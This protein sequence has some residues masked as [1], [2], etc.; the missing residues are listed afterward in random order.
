MFVNGVFREDLSNTHVQDGIVIT[1]LQS[2]WDSHESLIIKT[3]RQTENNSA[4]SSLN[5]AFINDGAFILIGKSKIVQKPIHILHI[6]DATQNNVIFQPHN[7]IIASENSQL[8][9]LDDNAVFG[10]NNSFNNTA[11]CTY[12]IRSKYSRNVPIDSKPTASFCSL[13]NLVEETF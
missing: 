3:V 8:T 2:A 12:S 7:I 13:V 5:K 11:I 6:A 9:L 4:F 10:K 1:N